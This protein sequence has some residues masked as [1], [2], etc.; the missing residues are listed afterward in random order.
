MGDHSPANQ[1]AKVGVGGLPRRR[2]RATAAYLATALAATLFLSA[3]TSVP[4]PDDVA[5]LEQSTSPTASLT[6]A[7]TAREMVKCLARSGIEIEA[8]PLDDGQLIVLPPLDS[9]SHLIDPQGLRFGGFDPQK[10]DPDLVAGLSQA[11][12]RAAAGREGKWVFVQNGED[13]S[14]EFEACAQETGYSSPVVGPD[15]LDEQVE[16][17]L[18]AQAAA[19]W[20]KCAREHGYPEIGDPEPGEVGSG[21]FP[22]VLLPFSISEEDLTALVAACPTF[23]R[24]VQEDFDAK[25]DEDPKSNPRASEVPHWPRVM[26]ELQGTDSPLDLD[27]EA[28]KRYNRLDAIINAEKYDYNGAG[29]GDD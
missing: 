9:V 17:Q 10:V 24:Q 16:R 11:I 5:T 12:D 19:E 18:Q 21:E 26:I 8:N 27:P 25:Y 28:Q 1:A 2:H 22:T 29:Y 4:A 6:Q 23:D 15:P 7:D 3:C 20:A 14:V 13:L